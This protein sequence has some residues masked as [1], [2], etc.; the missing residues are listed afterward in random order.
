MA[1]INDMA[2]LEERTKLSS[3]IISIK[4]SLGITY[5]DLNRKLGKPCTTS[6]L[7]IRASYPKKPLSGRLLNKMISAISSY[8]NVIQEEITH[9]KSL[10][11][12]KEEFM[13]DMSEIFDKH[14]R[15]LEEYFREN[16]IL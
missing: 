12:M 6:T 16:L 7:Q 10:S 8:E 11:L 5:H 1:K 15:R 14:S 9:K 13:N 3:K 2:S 4:S